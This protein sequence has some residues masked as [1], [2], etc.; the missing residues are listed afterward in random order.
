MVPATHRRHENAQFPL[1]TH[2]SPNLT[3]IT[4]E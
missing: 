2:L 4:D 1:L 3:M